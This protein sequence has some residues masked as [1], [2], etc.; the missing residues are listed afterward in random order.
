[1]EKPLWKAKKVL[2]FITQNNSL[3]FVVVKQDPELSLLYGQ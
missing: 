2:Y 1:M 3:S